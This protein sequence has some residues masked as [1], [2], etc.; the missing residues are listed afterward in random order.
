VIE[1][2]REMPAAGAPAAWG[3]AAL[4][5]DLQSLWPQL[6][7]QWV[8]RTASTNSLLL[9][10][11]R[12]ASA[13]IRA[14]SAAQVRASVESRAFAPR[15]AHPGAWLLVAESQTGGRGRHGRSWHAEA[16]ASLTFSLGLTLNRPDWSGLSLAAGVAVCEALEALPGPAGGA[17]LALK[18][19][20][21]LWFVGPG[22]QG[23]K[24]G[25][26]LIESVAAGPQRLAVVGVGLNI[27]PFATAETAAMD[28]GFATLSEVDP[29]ITAAQVL[30]RLAPALLRAMLQFDQDGFGAFI[31]R[32]NARD[33][34]MG[35]CVH[36]HVAATIEGSDVQGAGLDGV[37]RG[38]SDQG[39]LRV[40]TRD[41]W[42]EVSSGEVSVR[43]S[44]GPSVSA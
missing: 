15:P 12:A 14:G 22:A 44:S 6:R 7:V 13:A 26:I 25:G 3:L 31:S 41:G 5:R 16:G 1:P 27:R 8:E 29:A 11:A 43:L 2:A 10:R 21:D 24:L 42:I 33:M 23:R 4:E 18:W 40:Q 30:A 37:A 17:K 9:D 36:T 38:V 35:Q 34:L 39:A 28:T 19:P 32:Y 20:N